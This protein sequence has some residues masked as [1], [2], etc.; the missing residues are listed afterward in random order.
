[1]KRKKIIWLLLF[2]LIAWITIDIN[3][4]FKTDIH[5]IDAAETARLDGAMWKSYYEKKPVKLFMQSAQLMRNQFHFPFW[6]SYQVSYYAAKAAFVFK[7]GTNRNDYAK[8]LPYLQKYYGH[9]NEISNTAFNADTAAASE[10]EWWII[11]RERQQ[12]PP[13]EWE[14]WL[15]K[16]AS[17]MYHI[18]AAKFNDYA[19]LRVEAMLLRDEKGGNITEADWQKIDSLLLQAWQAFGKAVKA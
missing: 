17:V 15:C 16:T 14:E 9:I 11:R 18:P 1:M 5:T 8:A 13:Q 10:L 7:D 19:H 12:H 6:R 2:L 4:A 3:Y